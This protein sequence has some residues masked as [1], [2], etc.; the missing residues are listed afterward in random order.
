MVSITEEELKKIVSLA[1]SV[2]EE[3]REKCF[4]L[5]LASALRST[6][7]P[8]SAREASDGPEKA[9]EPAARSQFTLPIDVKAFLSQYQLDDSLLAKHFHVEGDQVVPIYQ[10]KSTKKAEA[11]IQHA[12]MMALESAMTSGAFQVEVEAL[13]QRCLDHRC[14]DKA[15]FTHI[16][17]RNDRLFKKVVTDEPLTLSPDGKAELAELLETLKG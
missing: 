2:P 11:Q 6:S 5:L 1:K 9:L 17:K 7:P 16:L 14:Y 12:L 4:E 10:L 13:R 3:Y 15:N 8:E